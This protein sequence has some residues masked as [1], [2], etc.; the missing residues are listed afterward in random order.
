M[1]EEAKR[2][3]VNATRGEMLVDC[4]TLTH[5]AWAQPIKITSHYPNVEDFLYVPM[6]VDKPANTENLTQQFKIIIQD[7]GPDGHSNGANGIVSQYL[8]MIPLDTA[9]PI[10][11]DAYSYH[12]GL[13][14]TAK[15]ADGPYS[16]QVR[17]F[18]SEAQG[19]GFTA[20]PKAMNAVKCGERGT[21]DRT[22]GL[23]RQFT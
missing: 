2:I 20:E 8:D 7:L 21:I 6:R 14:D 19:V 9:E 4:L 17:E 11:M 3:L 12:L 18:T 23:Y 1:I 13:D 15:L 5:S 16:V 22:G 10:L